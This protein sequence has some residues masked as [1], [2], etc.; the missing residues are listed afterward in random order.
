MRTY[1]INARSASKLHG[2]RGNSKCRVD[3]RAVEHKDDNAHN[4]ERYQNL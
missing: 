3:M 1:A 4:D 2:E